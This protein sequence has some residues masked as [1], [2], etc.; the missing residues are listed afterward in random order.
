MKEINSVINNIMQMPSEILFSTGFGLG[1][2]YVAYTIFQS[3]FG[4]FVIGL[5][6]FM[7]VFGFILED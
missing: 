3:I 1:S 7:V 6:V 2:G 4:G 5:S